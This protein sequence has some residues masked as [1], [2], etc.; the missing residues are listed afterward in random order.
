MTDRKLFGREPALVVG[1][2]GS[3]L[4]A[5]AALNLDFL[6]AGQ[7]AAITALVTAAIIAY[8][9][10]PKAPALFT[11]VF[12]AGVALIGEYGIDLSDELVAASTGL[13]VAVCALLGIR[14]QV[15]PQETAL[16][17]A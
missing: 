4:T 8:T 12:A 2:I 9:T 5:L 13:I 17:A 6:S 1:V 11:G 15:S 3:F 14:P 10:S 16:T 7:A